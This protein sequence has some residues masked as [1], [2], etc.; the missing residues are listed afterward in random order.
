MKKRIEYFSEKH[1]QSY[2]FVEA[3]YRFICSFIFVF[4]GSKTDENYWAQRHLNQCEHN[5]DDWGNKNTDWLTGYRNSTN[6]PHR[7]LL[8][9]AIS[10]HHP[11][12]ILE[13]G[14]NCGPNLVLLAKKFPFAEIIGIDINSLAVHQGNAWLKK[15]GIENVKLF[16]G[17][18][19]E[20]QQ[21]ADKKFDIVFTDA[22]L[23]YLAADT[24]SSAMQQMIRIANKAIILLEWNDFLREGNALGKFRK[25]WVRNY[26][27]LAKKY[28][29]SENVSVSKLPNGVWA[30]HKWKRYG[31]IIEVITH[32]KH[33]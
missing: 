26:G 25:H 17:K 14:C 12:S 1:P 4:R 33:T 5:K 6:H 24:I 10:K 21:F 16:V 9:D 7:K 32:N 22:V 13:I 28:V 11:S 3:V 27:A 2:R 31:A 18:T 29:D 20:L 15:Q 23:I 8:I 19:D 30:D